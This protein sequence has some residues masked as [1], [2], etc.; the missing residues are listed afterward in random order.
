MAIN[1]GHLSW[2]LVSWRSQACTRDV[3]IGA[4]QKPKR[5]RHIGTGS[6]ISRYIGMET[7]RAESEGRWSTSAYAHCIGRTNRKRSKQAQKSTMLPTLMKR[8]R[9]RTFS[10]IPSDSMH[11]A[12]TCVQGAKKAPASTSY[13]AGDICAKSRVPVS[14]PET[15]CT[16]R[17]KCLWCQIGTREEQFPGRLL[18]K[19]PN[20]HLRI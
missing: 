20:K 18:K 7:S 11:L 9:K 16:A 14:H 1:Y 4:H 6:E 5:Q 15:P 12:G 13:R 3:S 2:I 8:R 17:C 10:A 19:V